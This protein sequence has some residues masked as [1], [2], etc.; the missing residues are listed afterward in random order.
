MLVSD[1]MADKLFR[2]GCWVGGGL[3]F[4]G[5]LAYLNRDE[6]R[7]FLRKETVAVAKDVVDTGEDIEKF[8][9]PVVQENI[10]DAGTFAQ[11]SIE[12][13]FD[14]AGDYIKNKIEALIKSATGQEYIP[15]EVARY[16]ASGENVSGSVTLSN[17]SGEKKTFRAN[18]VNE[19][20]SCMR[21]L[22]GIDDRRWW[23]DTTNW[24]KRCEDVLKANEIYEWINGSAVPTPTDGGGS[25]VGGG[26]TGGGGS[27]G[28]TFLNWM[29]SGD[30]RY[31]RITDANGATWITR[32][33]K[34]FSIVTGNMDTETFTNNGW[35][36]FAYTSSAVPTDVWNGLNST[37][38]VY[39]SAGGVSPYASF[40]EPINF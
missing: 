36:K 19:Y 7:A 28:Y 39:E 20:C 6:I 35:P 21:H 15:P 24:G 1:K 32:H 4:L 22:A 26:S 8:L 30:Y 31:Y 11:T 2:A 3:I 29:E 34:T 25:T 23:V 10:L 14:R 40:E 16:L 37:N 17:Q 27:S 33:K 12:Q 13:G 18:Q 38:A 5:G 9:V